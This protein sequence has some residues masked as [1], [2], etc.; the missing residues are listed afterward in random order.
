[1]PKDILLNGASPMKMNIAFVFAGKQKKKDFKQ[2]VLE[3]KE[4]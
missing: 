4:V 2:T 1:M 3:I